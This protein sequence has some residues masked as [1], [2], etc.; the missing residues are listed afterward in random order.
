[1]STPYE[2][3]SIMLRNARYRGQRESEKRLA[4][5]NEQV[6]DIHRLHK[7]LKEQS[8]LIDKHT[9][10]WFEG[11]EEESEVIYNKVIEKSFPA[12]SNQTLYQ[13]ITDYELRNVNNVV[14]KLNS[15]TISPGDYEVVHGSIY[16]DLESTTSIIPN[17]AIL[18]IKMDAS[19]AKRN[20]NNRGIHKV[21]QCLRNID[22]RLKEAE[23]MY[24]KY[25]DAFE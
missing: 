19:I 4:S 16:I 13:V 9:K 6:F 11:T 8:E 7:Q 21:S 24:L 15:T 2:L 22:G 1:M 5:H 23:R 17:N 20:L 18:H 25:E 10:E 12:T 14:V 3:P